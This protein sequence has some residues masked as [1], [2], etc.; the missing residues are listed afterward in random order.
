MKEANFG[1]VFETGSFNQNF[2][3]DLKRILAGILCKLQ[4]E[5]ID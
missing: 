2:T 4:K 5:N 1:H 3:F